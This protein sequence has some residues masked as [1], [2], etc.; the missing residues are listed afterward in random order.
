MKYLK[1]GL[2]IGLLICKIYLSAQHNTLTAEEIQQ[3]KD[4]LGVELS[5]NEINKIAEI[6]KPSGTIPQWRIDAESRIEQHRKADLVVQLVD[7]DGIPVPGVNLHVN[8]RKNAFKF[9]GVVR[10]QDL[11]D[12]DGKLASAGSSPDD[13]KRLVTGLCNAL[14]AGNNFK[15]KLVNGHQYLPDFLT[16]TQS[17]SL[18]VRGHLLMW[19]GGGQLADLYDPN[20][21]SGTDYGNHLSRGQ[22]DPLSL[23]EGYEDIISYNV[24]G[25]VDT[26]KSSA[27]TQADKDALEAVVDAEIKQWAGLWNVYEWDVINETINNTLLMEI[28]GY[29]QMAEW[30]K[31]AAANVVN[32]DCKL[33]INEYQIVSATEDP[34]PPTWASY[35]TRKSK[36]MSRIDRVI[37]D[38]GRLDRIGFQNRY[39]FGVPNPVN[40]YARLNEF[41]LKYGREM[42]GTEFE[43]VDNP[44]SNYSPYDYS[45]EE[46]ARITEQTLTTYYSHPLTTGLFNWTFMHTNDEKALTYYDG[47]VKLNGLV[48]Y[49]LHRI[50]YATNEQIVSDENGN[51]SVR[52]FKGEYEL[53]IEY[54][55]KLYKQSIVLDGDS[56]IQF[57]LSD[58]T[59]GI[60][61]PVL[62][63]LKVYPN[64][65]NEKLVFASGT[66]IDKIEVM[67]I[68][69]NKVLTQINTTQLNMAHLSSGIYILKCEME[70]HSIIKKIVKN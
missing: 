60:H 29:N 3:Y 44:G 16:W 61:S 32:P 7:D 20:A 59:T 63:D 47:T 37:S 49:Y 68:F 6:V 52:A 66:P 40:T 58:S 22:T 33:L 36:Y 34:N 15:P 19:P 69:G 18:D 30:F 43:V 27:R 57:K 26:Y 10:A 42:V 2:L 8:L 9:G 31:I 51:C 65:V 1:I 39:K 38:G 67:D 28:M 48:W 14:G 4:D 56:T 55:D 21:L 46:R 5:E 35:D 70:K 45:E 23:I 54:Q 12:A 13:W 53:T 62:Q 25:A 41:A 64:P 24:L 50:R 11:T 17:E